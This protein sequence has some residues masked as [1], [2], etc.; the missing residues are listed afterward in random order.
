MKMT[1]TFCHY[2]YTLRFRPFL[3]KY[4]SGVALNRQFL[5][6]SGTY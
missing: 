5:C 2:P 6:V 1:T 3:L 4:K